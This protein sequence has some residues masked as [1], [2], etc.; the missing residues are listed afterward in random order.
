MLTKHA[1]KLRYLLIGTINTAIDFGVLFMLTWFIST[2]K[3]LA[4]IISTTIA[5]SFSFVANR[6]FTFRSRTGNVRQ[7]L[8]LFALVTLF[9]LWVIQTIIIALLAPIFISFNFS[10][11]T[12]LFAR[13][14]GALHGNLKHRCLYPKRHYSQ[15]RRNGNATNCRRKAFAKIY[16]QVCRISKKNKSRFATSG[17]S[18]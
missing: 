18:D 16:E 1:T 3:E 12:A 10:Q 6:S 17:H 11:P 2:P 8:L 15:A 14:A 7:Q 13:G 4:N 5:F 9:G